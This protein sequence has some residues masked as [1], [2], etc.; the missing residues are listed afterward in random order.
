MIQARTLIVAL[1]LAC[2]TVA[3]GMTDAWAERRVALV[4]GN[5]SYKSANL[6][7]MTPKTD[8]QDMAA[9]LQA[10][11]FETITAVDAGIHDMDLALAKFARLA[12][13]AD[14]ALFFYAGHGLQFQARNYLMPVDAD[15]DDEISIRYQTASLDNVL[16][17]LNRSSGVRI[18]ILDAAR[19]NPALDRLAKDLAQSADSRHI[20]RGLAGPDKISGMTVALSA[21]ANEIAPEGQGRNSP[22]TAALLRRMSEPGLEIDALFREAAADVT[23]R[24]GGRQRPEAYDWLS[25][26]FYLTPRRIADAAKERA[27]AAKR[28]EP[29]PRARAEEERNRFALQSAPGSHVLEDRSV[30]PGSPDHVVGASGAMEPQDDVRARSRLFETCRREEGEFAALQAAGAATREQLIRFQSG[31]RCNMLR[32]WVTAALGSVAADVGAASEAAISRPAPA[33][34][35]EASPSPR[36]GNTPAQIREAQQELKRVR[37]F[38]GR[39]DGD[40]NG[41]TLSA[42]RTYAAATGQTYTEINDALIADIRQHDDPVCGRARASTASRSITPR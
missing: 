20:H 4:V 25:G 41:P 17:A 7:L 13:G 27:A 2:L 34:G 28:A 5:S 18:M 12:T 42:A 9:A 38:A 29:E 33:T 24:T 36:P 3:A 21:A 30:L 37:C 31:L 23:A 15:L 10:L 1:V 39:V 6:S 35:Q 22:F 8:A 40:L 26:E 11:G 16:V 19:E 32:Q 14:V